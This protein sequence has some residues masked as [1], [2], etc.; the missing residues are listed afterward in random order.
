MYLFLFLTDYSIAIAS[1][2][3]YFFSHVSNLVCRIAVRASKTYRVI[4]SMMMSIWRKSPT[5][6]DH[7]ECLDRRRGKYRREKN[8]I[9]RPRY[10]IRSIFLKGFAYS[11]EFHASMRIIAESGVSV[12]V[13]S[14]KSSRFLRQWL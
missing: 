2:I 11:F 4:S 13:S 9:P 14:S 5:T 12:G 10:C 6:K 3:I 1:L 7:R 8:R